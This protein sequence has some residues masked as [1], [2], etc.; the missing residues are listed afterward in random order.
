MRFNV[1]LQTVE[2]PSDAGQNVDDADEV[3]STG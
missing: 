3:L 2:K 1:A